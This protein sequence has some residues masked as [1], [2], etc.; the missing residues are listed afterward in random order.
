MLQHKAVSLGELAHFN[1]WDGRPALPLKDLRR[2]SEC[3]DD[4]YGLVAEA[5]K[6]LAWEEEVWGPMV[7][8]IDNR[9]RL[10]A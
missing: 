2:L 8:E 9:S 10:E 4:Y 1:V 7:R 3:G 6:E 5:N